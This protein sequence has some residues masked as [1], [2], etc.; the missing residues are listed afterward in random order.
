MADSEQT[1]RH[2]GGL[3]AGEREQLVY[4]LETR[5]APALEAAAAAVRDAERALAEARERL[6]RAELPTQLPYASDPLIFMRHSV[7]EEIDGLERK[8][9]EKKV[10]A[11]YRFLLDRAVEL[12]GAEVTGF[13]D[14]QA[15]LARE[16]TEGL[17]ACRDDERRAREAVAAA[18]EMR[19]R[20][21]AA[22]RFA[23]RGLQTMVDKLASAPD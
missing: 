21:E 17:Q 11:S 7:E 19:G 5:F 2:P 10:R 9:T 1:T 6:A 14:S 20:V 23:R 13:H 22:E 16:R 8:T 3:A 18:R 15:G 12:A 4:T